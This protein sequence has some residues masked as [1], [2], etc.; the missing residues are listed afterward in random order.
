VC[1]EKPV[2]RVSEGMG[3]VGG[4]CPRAWGC[5]E[6]WVV[7]CLRQWEAEA[8]GSQWAV[9]LVCGWA[10]PFEELAVA[11]RVIPSHQGGGR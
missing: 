8:G 4:G 1:Y 6:R 7:A 9:Y 10:V 11:S 2:A 3:R 5:L